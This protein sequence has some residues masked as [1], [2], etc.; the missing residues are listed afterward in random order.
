MLSIIVAYDHNMAIAKENN[1]PWK[2]S[3]DLKNFKKIT[4]DKY[5]AMGRKT[6]ESI[7][8]PLPNRKN[9]IIT[10]DNDYT[11]EKCFILHS[12][13]DILNFVESKPHYEIFIIGGAEIYKEFL[14]FVDRIYATE[15]DT[16]IKNADVFFPA[17]NKER[18]RKLGKRKYTK[19]DKNEFNFEFIIYEKLTT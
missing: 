10:R 6:F 16:E 12:I 18:F 8:K 17:W 15:I 19:D 5:I 4:Q 13:Q 7:G 9:I 3:D 2:I 1:L 14:P 11:Q